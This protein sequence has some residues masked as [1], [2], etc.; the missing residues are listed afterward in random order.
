MQAHSRGV[1]TL[2]TY[3]TAVEAHAATDIS[4]ET[5]WQQLDAAELAHE[6]AE[7][8]VAAAKVEFEDLVNMTNQMD[9]LV[10]RVVDTNVHVH[11][12]VVRIAY[13]SKDMLRG[14]LGNEC[15]GF[16]RAGLLQELIPSQNW[17]IEALHLI[18]NTGNCWF[19]LAQNVS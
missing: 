14:L 8:E 15:E 1:A 6:S 12:V 19:E 13:I 3:T 11:K 9:G 16:H 7:E 10:V 4:V 18:L 2:A 5:A 17:Y